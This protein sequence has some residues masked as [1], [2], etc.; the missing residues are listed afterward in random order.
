[1]PKPQHR[2]PQTLDYDSAGGAILRY[3]RPTTRPAIRSLRALDI[4]RTPL[5]ETLDLMPASPVDGLLEKMGR[6]DDI[7]TSIRRY[8]LERHGAM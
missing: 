6:G 4:H 5:L 7:A 8:S 3:A 2:T 1:M